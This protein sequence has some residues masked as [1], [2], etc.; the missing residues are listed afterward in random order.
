MPK[1]LVTVLG[2]VLC[3]GVIAMGVFMV[4]LPLYLQSVD[5]DGQTATVAD[6]NRIYETQVQRLREEQE[7]LDEI[8][9]AVTELRTQVPATGEFDDVFEV[10][11]RAAEA[12]GVVLT[13][14]TAGQQVAFALRTG[15]EGGT[16]G[17]PST[18]PAAETQPAEGGDA[19]NDGT[20]TVPGPSA[21]G[22]TAEPAGGR[23]QV[24]FTIQAT[25]ADMAQA[26][27]FLDALRA[28]PRLLS[29]IKSTTTDSGEGFINVQLTALAYVDAEG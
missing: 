21:D 19:S 10:V 22:T 2:L 20:D 16:D 23:Q 3:L 12:T 17:A 7:R 24:D 9:A 13:S 27:A 5:V 14:V 29:T 4:A 11:G 15:E 6:T 1:Q 18:P 25:A 28:G 8:T 26:I